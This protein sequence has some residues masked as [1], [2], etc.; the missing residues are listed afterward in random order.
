MIKGDTSWLAT[1]IA[2]STLVAVMDG[3][4]MKDTYPLLNSAAFILSAHQAMA[5]SGDPSPN[6]PR[7]RAVTEANY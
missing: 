4:Y 1:S 3:S 7:M 6:I 2:S 5:G